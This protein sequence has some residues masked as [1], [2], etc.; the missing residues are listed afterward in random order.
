MFWGVFSAQRSNFF[1]AL[2]CLLGYGVGLPLVAF[3]AGAGD[4]LLADSVGLDGLFEP[5]QVGLGTTQGG[6][7][8][9]HVRV[10]LIL[11][12]PLPHP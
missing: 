11:G 7:G 12:R 3:G 5:V 10:G 6:L 8:S 1:Y 2:C 4:L 9:F